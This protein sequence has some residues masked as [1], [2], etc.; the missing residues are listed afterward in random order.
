L[1]QV[2]QESLSFSTEPSCLLFLALAMGS[3]VV[4]LKIETRD[5]APFGT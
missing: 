5:G 2:T 3:S 4:F 1:P